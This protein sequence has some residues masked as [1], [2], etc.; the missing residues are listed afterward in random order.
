MT[1]KVGEEKKGF[2]RVEALTGSGAIFAPILESLSPEEQE[3][4]YKQLKAAIKD[5]GIDDCDGRGGGWIRLPQKL[6]EILNKHRG[7]PGYIDS[8][9]VAPSSMMAIL[10]EE[11]EEEE[12][13][14][15][16][17]RKRSGFNG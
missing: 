15:K 12:E 8:I 17:K 4:T 16:K 10:E 13:E 14:E 2:E 7:T 3:E 6:Q 5:G 9:R 1:T 11:K